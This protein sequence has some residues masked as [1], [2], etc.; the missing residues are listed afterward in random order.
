[1]TTQHE[2]TSTDA[3]GKDAAVR[4][5]G[6]WVI[7]GFLLTVVISIWLLVSVIFLHRA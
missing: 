7:G 6:T 5:V 1:M 4:P 3:Q 2:P